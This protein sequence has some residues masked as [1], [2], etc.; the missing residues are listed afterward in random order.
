MILIFCHKMKGDIIMRAA[1]A[2]ENGEVCQH[3][4][5]CPEYTI[6]DIENNEV[7]GRSIF[8][9]PGHGGGCAMP[10]HLNNEKVNCVV[11]G[12]MGQKAIMGFEHYGIKM[13][14]GVT[15]TIDEVIDKL[16]KN[17]LEGGE[18]LCNHDGDEHHSC[19]HH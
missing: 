1:I 18:S 17:T 16:L 10:S 5:S 2:T 8:K 15:G 7:K 6:I 12:G 14:M 9:N 3:F 4:G 11:A 13:F 19:H